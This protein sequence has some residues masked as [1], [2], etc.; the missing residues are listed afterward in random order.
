MAF[1]GVLGEGVLNETF[2]L[3][4]VSD[5]VHEESA[6]TAIV[7]VQT[8]D[9]EQLRHLTAETTITFDTL[10]EGH[11]VLSQSAETIISFVQDADYDIEY[12]PLGLTSLIGSRSSGLDGSTLVLGF[13][14]SGGIF[15]LEA[16]TTITFNQ[17]A[18]EGVFIRFAETTITFVLTAD[19]INIKEREA[20]TDIVFVETLEVHGDLRVSAESSIVFF[21]E[22]N[23]PQELDLD[24]ETIITFT[25]Q[26]RSGTI[27]QSLETT[28]TFF[29]QA[30]GV[31]IGADVIDKDATTAIVFTD[32][33]TKVFI[34]A[35]VIDRDAETIISFSSLAFIPIFREA[36]TA[37]SFNQTAID[38]KTILATTEIPFVDEATTSTT[39]YRMATTAIPFL[40]ALTYELAADL[41]NYS[42][43]GGLRPVVPAMIKQ[44]DIQLYYPVYSPFETSVTIRAPEFGNRDQISFD[45]INQETR[46]GSLKIFADP[47]WAKEQ[48]LILQFVALTEDEAQDVLDFFQETLGKEIGI[49]DWENRLW[50]GIITTPDAQLTRH[51]GTCNVDLSFEFNGHVNE[52]IQEVS[53]DTPIVFVQ[54]ADAVVV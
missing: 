26:A 16:E 41:C 27:Q 37:I 15:D 54:G 5:S 6:D 38:N 22:A 4:P 20:L 11:G 9:L 48:I 45:R 44:D 31:N 46:G 51:K 12:A 34:S 39:R 33:A 49:R 32:I 42:P 40:Q 23:V 29:D 21:Q 13:G 47:T 1:T 17:S 24:A 36:A 14:S 30:I 2:V 25:D 3:A 7:F 43:A 35:D 19:W 28:I 8:I 10:A 52:V 53:A 18:E 50:R